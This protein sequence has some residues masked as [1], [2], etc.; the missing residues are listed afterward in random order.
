MSP[1]GLQT[2]FYRIL[3]HYT[4]LYNSK[5]NKDIDAMLKAELPIYIDGPFFSVYHGVIQIGYGYAGKSD[6]VG[7]FWA[8][9]DG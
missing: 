3:D 4:K 7:V 1:S 8:I 6:Q 5:Y 9:S 2:G